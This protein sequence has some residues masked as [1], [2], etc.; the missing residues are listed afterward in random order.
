MVLM[1]FR[2]QSNPMTGLPRR[3]G[4]AFTL[5]ELL[6]V[7]SIIGLIA[8]IGLPAIKGM[9]RSHATI[10]STRQL[11]DDLSYARQR[12]IADHTTV[13]MVFVPPDII[14]F[15]PPADPNGLTQYT[16]LLGEQYTGYAVLSKR[17]LGEQPGRATPRYLTPWRT[18]PAGAFIATNKFDYVNQPAI[19][20]QT[21]TNIPFPSIAA[22]PAQQSVVSLPCVAFNYRGQLANPDGSPR[23]TDEIIPLA[24]GGIFYALNANGG[25]VNQAADVAENPPGNSLPTSSMYN[26]IQINALTGRAKIDRQEIQ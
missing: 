10:S 18:L 19:A 17:Q 8:A 14:N 22:N 9:S 2:E 15:T 26:A 21:V 6:V 7:I 11:L 4:R 25:F 24:R 13:Y 16:N 1:K 23:S 20:F 3:S 5:V 12:A